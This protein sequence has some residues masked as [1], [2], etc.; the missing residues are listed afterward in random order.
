MI[1]TIYTIPSYI[2]YKDI[3][4]IYI[5]LYTKLTEFRSIYT[6]LSTTDYSCRLLCTWILPIKSPV[7]ILYKLIGY[8]VYII[9]NH[10]LY[11]L[12]IFIIVG[13]YHKIYNNMIYYL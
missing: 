13:Y 8:V 10:N 1:Y 9:N 3:Y 11:I 7:P 2:S 12:I 4:F 5:L 6:S